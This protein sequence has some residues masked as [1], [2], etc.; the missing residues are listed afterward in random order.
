MMK[1]VKVI[2][3]L[4]Q[5][6]I[7]IARKMSCLLRMKADLFFQLILRN[8]IGLQLE[9]WGQKTQLRHK[10]EEYFSK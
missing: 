3:K 5:T 6:S 2:L 8:L 9:I 1:I 4:T 10:I 7:I